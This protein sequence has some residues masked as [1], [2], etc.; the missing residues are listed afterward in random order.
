[1]TNMKT[2]IIKFELHVGIILGQFETGTKTISHIHQKTFPD[3]CFRF[4]SENIKGTFSLVL[5]LF[6]ERKRKRKQIVFGKMFG[7]DKIDGKFI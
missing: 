4:R 6:R 7:E 5:I 1:M 3:D 2:F